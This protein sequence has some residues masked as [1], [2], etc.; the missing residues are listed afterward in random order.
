MQ[1]KTGKVI[2]VTG[3]NDPYCHLT[4]TSLPEVL[5]FD[6]AGETI[7][8]EHGHT[9]GA[10]QPCHESLR[11][12]HPD[13][14]IIIYGHTHKKIIDKSTTPWV[15]NPGAAGNTRTHGGPS[16]LVIE[17]EENKEWQI[18]KYRFSEVEVRL[19]YICV[20]IID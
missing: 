17:C 8:V 9:H 18:K 5:S 19:I 20:Y 14:K 12:A 7:T 3:N 1:P 10:H 13:A 4:G 16:C 2:A 11:K 15:I 6:V